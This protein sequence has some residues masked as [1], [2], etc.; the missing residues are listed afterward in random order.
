[1]RE[2]RCDKRGKVMSS[3]NAFLQPSLS[4]YGGILS[5]EASDCCDMDMCDVVTDREYHIKT[6]IK[7]IDDK[8][9]EESSRG[10]IFAK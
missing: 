5:M 4:C 6:L 7:N 8:K 1:M 9:W 3:G 10:C 2:L